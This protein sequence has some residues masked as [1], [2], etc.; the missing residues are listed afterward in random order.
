[1]P[2]F[3]DASITGH[4]KFDAWCITPDTQIVYGAT[5]TA[6]VL[7]PADVGGYVLD[8][9]N[10]DLAAWII[11]QEFV[12]KPSQAGGFHDE[13]CPERHLAAGGRFLVS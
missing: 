13:R 12:G 5:Y 9:Q 3:F 7:S 1:M 4:G 10:L 11:N 8:P 2:A 6:L